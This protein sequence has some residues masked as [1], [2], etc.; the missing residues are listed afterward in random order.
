MDWENIF[1]DMVHGVLHLQINQPFFFSLRV[2]AHVTQTCVPFGTSQKHATHADRHVG[3]GFD[4][5]QNAP[6]KRPSARRAFLIIA[7]ASDHQ[8]RD[9]ELRDEREKVSEGVVGHL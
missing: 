8:K 2:N 9:I 6:G 4:A 7:A 5:A 3:I 1:P